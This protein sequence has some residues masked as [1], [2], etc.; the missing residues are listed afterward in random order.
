MKIKNLFLVLLVAF[1]SIGCEKNVTKPVPDKIN[2]NKNIEKIEVEDKEI[3]KY[4]VSL[5]S[6]P[7]VL[8]DG[9][10]R[11]IKT[12][13]GTYQEIYVKDKKRLVLSWAENLESGFKDVFD[14][15]SLIE[16]KE[17][18]IANK[19]TEVYLLKYASDIKEP[20]DL[21]ENLM[22]IPREGEYEIRW[23]NE[24][25]TYHLFGTFN[26]DELLEMTQSI[27]YD[28]EEKEK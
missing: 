8:A 22:Q 28:D 4:D 17:V 10:V 24:G 27:S 2:T 3:T 19:P 11:F 7:T 26:T 9:N 14:S 20:S 25:I 13:S 6:L 12:K 21:S 18:C 23:E 15:A 5:D 1:C 16:K